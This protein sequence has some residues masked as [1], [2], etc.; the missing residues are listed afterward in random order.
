MGGG[1]RG[2]VVV[3]GGGWLKWISELHHKNQKLISVHT[4]VFL[5]FLFFVV[6]IIFLSFISKEYFFKFFNNFFFR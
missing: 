2:W 4:F 5:L 3:E 1:R 6:Y